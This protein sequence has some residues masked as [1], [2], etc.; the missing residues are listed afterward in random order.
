MLV[1]IYY[2]ACNLAWQGGGSG[3][4]LGARA[5]EEERNG[6]ESDAAVMNIPLY[7]EISAE[8]S[9]RNWLSPA[10][11]ILARLHC[12]ARQPSAR[13]GDRE[14]NKRRITKGNTEGEATRPLSRTPED[15]NINY[16][17]RP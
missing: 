10:I 16:N 4:G 6:Y 5:A 17:Q 3:E 14:A 15:G 13:V 12:E 2:L 8:L 11:N 7:P 1:I 9:Q